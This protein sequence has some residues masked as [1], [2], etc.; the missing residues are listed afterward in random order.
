[1]WTPFFYLFPMISPL[2]RWF[3]LSSNR[4]PLSLLFIFSFP[5]KSLS[6][7]VIFMFFARKSTSCGKIHRP[8]MEH[9]VLRMIFWSKLPK[10]WKNPL[11]TCGTV[12]HPPIRYKK[13]QVVEKSTRHLW[14]KLFWN[15]HSWSQ[16]HKSWKTPRGTC[17]TWCF[18]SNLLPSDLFTQTTH[19]SKCMIRN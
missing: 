1:L 5:F 18:V 13:P 19:Q 4:S 15:S 6:V 2:L 14:N 17:G 3:S 10:S 16:I 7:H 8:P 9:V 11:G 12:L